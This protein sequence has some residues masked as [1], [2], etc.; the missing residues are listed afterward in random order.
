MFILS[1]LGTIFIFFI[2]KDDDIMKEELYKIFNEFTSII[3][4]ISTF[5]SSVFGIEW[6]LFAGYLILN[7]I[8]YLTGTIKA[9]LTKSESSNKGLIGIIKKICYWILLGI[10]F[11]ISY[12]LSQIGL[13]LNINLDFII[14]FGWFT[15]ACLI[16]NESRS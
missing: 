15:L 13:K 3:S 5:L 6:P 16:V 9:K 8:D 12:L 4:I 11:F 7:L 10:S 2:L 1:Y 14:L